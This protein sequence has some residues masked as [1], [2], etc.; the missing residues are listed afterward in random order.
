MN[1]LR[2]ENALTQVQDHIRRVVDNIAKLREVGGEE[3]K[4]AAIEIRVVNG[5][6]RHER[7]CPVSALNVPQHRFLYLPQKFRAYVAGFGAG[8]I[9]LDVPD[10][11]AI[12]GD[13]R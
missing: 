9:G 5:G 3:E 8:K 13:G 2:L 11:P 4:P 6:V 1:I 10:L 7:D 12:F